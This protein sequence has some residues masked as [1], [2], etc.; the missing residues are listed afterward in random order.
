MRRFGL[1]TRL[2]YRAFASQKAQIMCVKSH[3]D[4]RFLSV[5]GR[6]CHAVVDI[7]SEV[8]CDFAVRNTVFL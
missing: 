5:N 6:F 2:A 1:T 7:F 4:G 8:S 3:M